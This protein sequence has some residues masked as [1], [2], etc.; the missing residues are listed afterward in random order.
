MAQSAAIRWFDRQ[1]YPDYEDNWDDK[2]FAEA[3]AEQVDEETVVLDVGAGAGIVEEMNFRGRAA[4]V[5]GIDLDERVLENDYLDEAHVARGEDIPY[6]DDT[7]DVVF[8]DNVLEHLEN[9][10]EVF[11]EVARVLK[12]GGRF[13]AKTPNRRH[14]MPL[15]AASTPHWFHRL[16]N[17]LR[18][19]AP[20]DT[21]HTHYRANTPD[22][23][24]AIA[25]QVGMELDEATLIEGRPE[26]LR[27]SP[28][29]YPVGIAYERLVNAID[30][31]E[32]YRVVMIARFVLPE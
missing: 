10:R 30:A 24:R 14:Y 19:R 6:P 20:D 1:F 13:L 9:P 28:L 32:R 31:L 5:C 11:A 8:S 2:L 16:Y 3:I 18:G 27:I 15:I 25:E 17:W 12:P 26:Y 29:T 4:K 22:D 21:F 23:V 7:F